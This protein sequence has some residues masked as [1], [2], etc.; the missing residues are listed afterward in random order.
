MN[1]NR[2]SRILI[3][4][5]F[6]IFTLYLL[7]TKNVSRSSTKR[8][9]SYNIVF[10]FEYTENVFL[11]IGRAFVQDCPPGTE[12]NSKIKNCD[13]PSKA[14]CKSFKRLANRMTADMNNDYVD[15]TI[16]GTISFRVEARQ[17]YS[18]QDIVHPSPPSG[19]RVR[20]RYGDS[21]SGYLEIF[22][23]GEWGLV[24]DDDWSREE[25]D[26]VCKQLG[27]TRGVASTTQVNT[28]SIY[29]SVW[30]SKYDLYFVK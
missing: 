3:I 18:N 16:N 25:A 19:Q 15:G 1:A 20:L 11:L 8:I 13:F 27:F 7:T 23:S 9:S 14:N 2:E 17:G 30:H 6:V 28:F 24:C 12:F 29:P 22:H 10:L 26:I 21:Y 5:Y 4:Q